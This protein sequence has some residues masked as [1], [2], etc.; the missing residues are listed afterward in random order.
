MRPNQTMCGSRARERRRR[1]DHQHQRAPADRRGQGGRGGGRGPRPAVRDSGRDRR[2]HPSPKRHRQGHRDRLHSEDADSAR[3]A[4]CNTGRFIR[5]TREPEGLLREYDSLDRALKSAAGGPPYTN[6]HC[7]TFKARRKVDGTL[8]SMGPKNKHLIHVPSGI[9]L[10][11]FTTDAANWGMAMFV[12]TGPAEWNIR[13]MSRFQAL[14]MK[15]HAYGGVTDFDGAEIECRDE[16]TVFQL[17]QWRYT[18][19]EG[20]R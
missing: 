9:R 1:H 7:D 8:S 4:R 6:T 12:R 3:R 13:A 18:P 19:P 2:I 5:V 17:L 20:R 10:D 11:V 15:G 16:A 14:G